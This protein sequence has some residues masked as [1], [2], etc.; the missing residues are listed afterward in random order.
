MFVQDLQNDFYKNLIGKRILVIV[1]ID[2]D[3]ICSTKI[4]QTLFRYDNMIYTMV[5]IM[6][7]SGLRRAYAE[8]KEDVKIII[9]INCGGCMDLLEYLEL[10]DDILIY[11]C[12]NHRPY[13]VF[14]VYSS[15]QVRIIK[16]IFIVNIKCGTRK[17][18]F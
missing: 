1:N 7:Q 2:C 3:A 13:D 4:L 16:I 17:N 9:L 11:V 12:D 6:G 14:N 5:P 18:R 8:Y 15:S 10:D